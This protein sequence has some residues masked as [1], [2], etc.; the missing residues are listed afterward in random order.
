MS[1]NLIKE[2]KIANLSGFNV[3]VDRL[4]FESP[5]L[6][7]EFWKGLGLPRHMVLFPNPKP[8]LNPKPSFFMRKRALPGSFS[9][10]VLRHPHPPS[11]SGQ[12]LPAF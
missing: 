11:L 5:V 10:C 2:L 6:G 12:L 4:R 8:S 1:E 7:L 9:F 3:R